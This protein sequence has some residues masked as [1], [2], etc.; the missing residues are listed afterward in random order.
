MWIMSFWILSTMFSLIY[1]S[2]EYGSIPNNIVILSWRYNWSHSLF[3]FQQC[4]FS[5]QNLTGFC[6]QTQFLRPPPFYSF[7]SIVRYFLYLHFQCYPLSL[8][9]FWNLPVQS[10]FPVFNN[11]TLLL[12]GPGI[13][14]HWGLEPM[15]GCEHPLLIWINY[16][17][18]SLVP[19]LL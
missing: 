3:E 16:K 12:P 15:V 10:T 6:M 13:P 1:I 8:F 7:F 2:S 5:V 14:L 11:P 4:I 19:T 17:S 9:L 18:P